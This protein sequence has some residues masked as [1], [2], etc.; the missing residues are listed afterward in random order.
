MEE[1]YLLI[2]NCNIHT[3][4]SY[5]FFSSSKHQEDEY[6]CVDKLSQD[7]GP[8]LFAVFDGHG[9]DD[10][11]AHLFKIFLFLLFLYKP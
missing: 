2:L 3:Q 11:S 10:F 6:T 4:C 5:W 7:H 9:T 1:R 8:A